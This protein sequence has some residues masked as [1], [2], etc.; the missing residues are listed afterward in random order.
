VF[1]S[2]LRMTTKYGFSHVRDQLLEGLKEAYP[3]K[4]ESFKTAR[5]LGEDVFGLPKPHPNSVLNLFEEQGV[6]FAIPFAAYRASVAGF[7]SL[8]SDKPGT[9]LSRRTLGTTVQGMHV[10]SSSVSDVAHEVV[11]GGSVAVCPNKTCTLNVDEEVDER[12]EALG[13]VYAG[14]AE[15]REGGWLKPPSSGNLCTECAKGVE[16]AH[17]EWGSS[18]WDELPQAFNISRGWDSL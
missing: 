13:K 17:D 9:V 14:M 5:V 12:V 15:K 1:A 10:L 11:Y 2:L 6:R 18:F 8:M 16:A 3:I 4:W 7:R